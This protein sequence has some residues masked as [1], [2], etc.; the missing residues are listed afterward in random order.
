[1]DLIFARR[2][3]VAV[4]NRYPIDPEEPPRAAIAGTARSDEHG[5]GERAMPAI[6]TFIVE[7]NRIH[8]HPA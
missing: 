5:R 4:H 1:M 6:G 2:H 8:C 3:P 7:Q